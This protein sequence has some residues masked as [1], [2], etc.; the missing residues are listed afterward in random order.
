MAVLYR[1]K[2][3]DQFGAMASVGH[4]DAFPSVRLNGRC[5]IRKRPFLPMIDGGD[6]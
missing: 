1:P 5:R 3:P 6:F 4:E 2:R